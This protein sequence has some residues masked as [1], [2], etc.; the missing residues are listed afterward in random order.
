[1][2][3]ISA[4]SAAAALAFDAGGANRQKDIWIDDLTAE[5]A[6]KVVTLHGGMKR[7][8]KTSSLPVLRSRV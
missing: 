5:E 6:K 2:V 1:M 3:I 4:S 7:M 8:L